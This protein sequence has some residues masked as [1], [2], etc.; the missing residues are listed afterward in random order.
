MSV[1]RG[2]LQHLMGRQDLPR[3]ETIGGVEAG[4]AIGSGLLLEQ[5]TDGTM[6]LLLESG[7]FL[8]LE[9]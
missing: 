3:N 4:P 8:L 1:I 7:D 9:E 5:D 6:F 2:A